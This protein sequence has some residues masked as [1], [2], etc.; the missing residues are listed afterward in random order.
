MAALGIVFAAPAGPLGVR[1]SWPP[2][3]LAGE[4]PAGA[5]QERRL[6]RR[7]GVSRGVVG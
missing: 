2:I 5:K 3:L 6:S 7:V 1:P 4:M